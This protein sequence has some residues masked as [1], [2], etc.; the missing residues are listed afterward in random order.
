MCKRL[1]IS[2]KS[3]VICACLL[4]FAKFS[5]FLACIVCKIFAHIDDG[6]STFSIPLSKWSKRNLGQSGTVQ[7]AENGSAKCQQLAS[8]DQEWSANIVVLKDD[9]AVF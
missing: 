3:L 5:D 9:K 6:L 1:T 2:E 8:L 7:Q 4:T